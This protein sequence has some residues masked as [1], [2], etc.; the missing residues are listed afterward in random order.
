MT[1]TITKI[2][3]SLAAYLASY[4]PGVTFYENPNQQGTELPCMF[5]QQRGPVK[6]E[7]KLSDR[8]LRTIALDLTYLDDYNLTDLQERYQAV[9]EILDEVLETFPYVSGLDFTDSSLIRTYNRQWNTDLD[10]LHYKFEIRVW[11][12]P[13]EDGTPMREYTLQE[14]IHVNS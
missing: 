8:Y 7:N 11:V 12:R 2:A 5:L 13:S 1:F 9:A 10:G 14:V 4:L 6:I 3:E